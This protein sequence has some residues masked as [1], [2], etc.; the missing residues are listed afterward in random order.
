VEDIPVIGRVVL[1][2]EVVVRRL[3][4]SRGSRPGGGD[5]GRIHARPR[6][7]FPPRSQHARVRADG[8]ATGAPAGG[9][10]TRGDLVDVPDVGPGAAGLGEE[11]RPA[12]RVLVRLRLV[13]PAGELVVV[14]PGDFL[15]LGGVRKSRD[16][17]HD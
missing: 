9:I 14:N 8:Y 2:R 5:G 7:K 4:R 17:P 16:G 10:A 13:E 1:D 12:V 11:E 15:D 6:S 3:R